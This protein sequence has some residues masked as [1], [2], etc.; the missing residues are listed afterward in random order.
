[1]T[2]SKLESLYL[3]AG[4]GKTGLS[5]ARYLKRKNRTFVAFDTR[6][7]G[8]SLTEFKD[9]FP[10]VTLYLETLPESLLA[11]LTDI[12]ISPGLPLIMPFIKKAQEAGIAI[13]GDIECLAREVSAPIIAIT[14]TNGKSTVTAL[15]GEMAK[16]QGFRVA[17]AGN[18]GTSV[19]DSLIE[20][21]KNPYALWV[22]ELSSFQLE[23]THSLKAKIATVLNLSPDHL[24]RHHSVAAYAQAKK[25]NIS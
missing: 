12:I 11:T 1:M 16:A 19:L 10:E 8:G 7:E 9:E 24:D 17:V 14:G 23:V 18:I 5:V 22:L 2:K 21:E 3:V 4:L 15:V 6:Q 25:K 13:Y 20:H